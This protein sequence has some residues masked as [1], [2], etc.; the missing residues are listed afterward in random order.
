[1]C[2]DRRNLWRKRWIVVRRPHIFMYRDEKDP[3]ERN[4][5]NLLN[6]TVHFDPEEQGPL[7]STFTIE[8]KERKWI[9]QPPLDKDVHDWVYAIHPLLAGQIRSR[10]AREQKLQQQQQSAAAAAAAA[11]NA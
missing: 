10:M 2:D 6:A 9:F 4:V 8:T 11:R 1:M 5:I 3:V 7:G